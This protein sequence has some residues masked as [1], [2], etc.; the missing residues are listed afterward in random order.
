M[1]II[2]TLI[3]LILAGCATTYVPARDY[4]LNGSIVDAYDRLTY[5]LHNNRK[6]DTKYPQEFV[7]EFPAV[8][9]YGDGLFT[10]V[11]LTDFAKTHASME[12]IQWRLTTYCATN[13]S[14]DCHAAI[15]R[16]K[17]A[18]KLI[19]P[20]K[21]WLN[22]TKELVDQLSPSEKATLDEKFNLTLYST[23]NLGIVTDRQSANLS[24]P[25]SAAGSVAGAAAGSAIYNVNSVS[26]N[27]PKNWSYSPWADLGSAIL[28][29]VVGSAADRQAVQRYH[30][31]YAV[32]LLNGE[33]I[34]VDEE[35]Q[36]PVGHA[37]GTCVYIKSLAKVSDS[38]CTMTVETLRAELGR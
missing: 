3:F 12:W 28:G 30:F 37:I 29:A 20:P 21:P 34:T 31:R 35:Y 23:S 7:E 27:N 18:E 17:N 8:K 25:G 24:T 32:K 6:G 1:K 15:Q 19:K 9:V 4:A 10:E 16:V 5:E 14:E 13:V 11:A 36:S 22:T 38:L 2:A 26:S 33:T